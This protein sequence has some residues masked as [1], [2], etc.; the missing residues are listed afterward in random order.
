MIDEL[1]KVANA[2]EKADIVPVDWHPK[3]K[4]LPKVTKKAPCIRIWLT[5]DGHIKNLESLSG[6]HVAI[7]RKYEPDNGKS[8]PGFNVRPLY[9]L[10]RS[11]E[12]MKGNKFEKN[13]VESLK[14]DSFDWS[15]YMLKEDDFWAKTRDGLEACFG[16]VREQLQHLCKVRLESDET[17][18]KLLDTISK[19]DL[20]TFQFEYATALRGKIEQGDLPISLMCYFV[21][22]EKKRTEDANPRA[23]IPK[24]SIFL[25][26]TDYTE[27]PVAHEKTIARLNTL[28]LSGV[29]DAEKPIEESFGEDAYGLDAR[30]V[31]DKFPGVAIPFLGGVILRSQAKSIPAQM[32][33]H[34]CESNTFPVGADTRRRTKAALEWISNPER[35]GDT[36]GVA[37]DQEL[38]FAYPRV[39]P[40]GKIPIAKMFG[41]QKDENLSE[42][43]FKILSRSVIKQLKGLGKPTDDAELEI[44]TLRKMDKAR[45]KVVYYR[46]VTV[47]LLETASEIWCQGCQNIPVLDVRDWSQKMDEETGKSHPVIVESSVVFPIKLHRYLNAVWKR[48]GKRAD[49]GKSK[50]SIFSPSDG[51]QLMLEEQCGALTK[52]MMERLMQQAQGYFL[53]LCCATGKREIAKL[54]DKIYYPGILGLLLFK[55]GKRKDEYMKESAFLLGRF[56]RVADEI[57][58]LYC[59]VVRKSALPPE[60]CGSSLLVGMMESPV[61]TLDQLA[62]RS[63]PYVKWARAYHGDD[64]GGLVHY[65]MQHWADISDQLHILEW[66]KRLYSE[67]RAQVF[68][69][70]LASFP[71][72]E[73]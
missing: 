42:E 70:Y 67:E 37:G 40:K 14:K 69:G 6:E 31:E 11:N 62:M 59:E 35:N 17:L 57:H 63:A 21:T 30:Q 52:Y 60:L 68:L 4:V 27:Y 20:E 66:P 5:K 45:T 48:D 2:M 28:L 58:R 51:L 53:S 56:L 72:G 1:V 73:K 55:S 9:R 46:N 7:L 26:V 41:A 61:R 49:T 64:K 16:R 36:Y 33:Y 13:L 43:Q 18:A 23:P 44:F 39:L 38:L 8:L 12:E 71:K 25:D 3:L 54:P 15:L 29:E 24:F 34:Q 65:W 10:V 50:V 47:P 22:E 32:R 19:I